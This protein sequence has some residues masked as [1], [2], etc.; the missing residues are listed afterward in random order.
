MHRVLFVTLVAAALL[1]APTASAG[2]YTGLRLVGAGNANGDLEILDDAGFFTARE[3]VLGFGDK[4]QGE[5]GFG[6]D[7][8]SVECACDDEIIPERIISEDK[9]TYSFMSFAIAGFYPVAGEVDGNRI[10]IG[11]RFSYMS[12]KSKYE[13][14]YG[15]RDDFETEYGTSGWSIGPVMRARWMCA[16]DRLGIGPEVALKY[17]SYT[18]TE[19]GKYWGDPYD[20]PDGDVSTW[21]LEYSLRFDFFFDTK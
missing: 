17:G 14:G 11:M 5:F 19:K 16:N 13:G 6:F 4:I 15:V 2:M 21:N 20:E 8:M 18:L 1:I 12:A 9:G 3:F 10:D 7:N